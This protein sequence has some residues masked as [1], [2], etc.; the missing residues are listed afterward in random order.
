M[1]AKPPDQRHEVPSDEPHD[2]RT[3]EPK[4]ESEESVPPHQPRRPR[5]RGL[6]IG[7]TTGDAD[8]QLE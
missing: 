3:D 6:V 1:T 2:N 5:R 4:Q 8:V 7:P